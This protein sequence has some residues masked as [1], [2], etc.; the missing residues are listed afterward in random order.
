MFD[1]I[2]RILRNVA[3]QSEGRQNKISI[4][5]KSGAKEVTKSKTSALKRVTSKS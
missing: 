2:V 5:M 4:S 1:D 3:I